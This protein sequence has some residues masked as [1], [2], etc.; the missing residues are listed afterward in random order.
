MKGKF[1]IAGVVIALLVTATVVWAAYTGPIRPRQV[2][3]A[4]GQWVRT[5]YRNN[6]WQRECQCG[7]SGPGERCGDNDYNCFCGQSPYNNSSLYTCYEDP[8]QQLV[9]HNPATASGSFACGTTGNS[10]WCRATP[11]LNV[12][13]NEPVSGYVIQRMEGNYDGSN[14][15]AVSCSGSSC[16]FTP[17]EGTG[18]FWYWAV[19]SYGDTSAK[20]SMA[21]KVDT[22]SPTVSLAPA[23]T[24]GNN[25]WYRSP[26][27]VNASASDA[28]SGLATLTLSCGSNPCTV[29]AEGTTTVTAT[30]ADVAG[31]TAS[32]NLTVRVDTVPPTPLIT[33]SGT[34]GKNGWYTSSV[35]ATAGGNDATSG[36][37]SAEVQLDGG[38]WGSTAQVGEG[39]HTLT[40]RA[41]DVAGNAS[42]EQ[43][44]VV[45]VDTTPP[46]VAV[47][48]PVPDGNNGWYRSSV[49]V[50]GDASDTGSGMADLRGQVNHGGW[51]SLPFSL[52]SDGVY[53]VTLEGEDV[54]GNTRQ[55]S[56]EVKLDSQP[57]ALSAGL[58]GTPG[59]NGW[60]VSEVQAS[61]TASDLLSGMASARWRAD[62]GSWMSTPLL[63]T[64]G[65]HVLELEGEDVAG[66]SANLQQ[67]VRVDTTPPQ[68]AFAVSGKEG[69]NGWYRS[70]AA[71]AVQAVD[72]TSG[73]DQVVL[74]VNGAA[75]NETQTTLEDGVYQVSAYSVDAAG[76][77]SETATLTVQVDT[78]PPQAAF[79]GFPDRLSR[80]VE[81]TGSAADGT[82]GLQAVE[83]SLDGGRTWEALTVVNGEWS[84]TWDTTAALG[85]NHTLLLRVVDA[86]GNE[87]VVSRTVLVANRAPS[88]WVTAKW[89]VWESGQVDVNAG[90]LPVK[91]VCITI[92]DPQ[93]RWPEV[94][95]CYD[96]LQD[97][98]REVKWDRRFAD[99]TRAP[100]GSYEVRVEITDILGQSDVAIGEI[101]VPLLAV[102]L[103]QSEAT[104]TPTATPT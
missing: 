88:A 50:N 96:S 100:A 35:T 77:V 2:W 90:D 5:I 33:L 73:V 91:R 80:T 25:G 59:N 98:P 82:S 38:G 67:V 43:S 47:L 81:L 31:N 104:P 103:P 13:G 34:S 53:Q 78:T 89:S 44:Q 11:R 37:A 15:A 26:V 46:A 56:A 18:T 39:V 40:F 84:T 32:Q 6:P 58:S 42:G 70:P 66:N 101:V 14:N 62:G 102:L 19:S 28:T 71:V 63:L 93:D 10:G 27:T 94:E 17:P 68:T 30:A 76:L 57:P 16:S 74:E 3:V 86:A 7:M 61:P 97:V 92:R 9:T 24:S 87:T 21:Y 55:R 4:T 64:D 85:G 51:Q 1:W 52:D 49:R 45:R 99:G 60:Y 8:V 69:R 23:G 29:S 41:A 75:T 22:V 65:V 54:A 48:L 12:S 83:L 79:G 95:N 36:V 20:G 72:A